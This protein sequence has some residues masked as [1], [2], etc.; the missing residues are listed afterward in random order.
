MGEETGIG[1]RPIWI[2]NILSFWLRN[3]VNFKTIL[4]QKVK[5]N[6]R[7]KKEMETS[8]LCIKLVA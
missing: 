8:D 6:Y 7:N 1:I 2:Y 3:H 5:I 4:N